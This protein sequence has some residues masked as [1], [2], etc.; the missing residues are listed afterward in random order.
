MII[1]GLGEAVSKALL[2]IKGLTLP[3][4]TPSWITRVWLSPSTSSMGF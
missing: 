3:L 4:S 1:P 2:K